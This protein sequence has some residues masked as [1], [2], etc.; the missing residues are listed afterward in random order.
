MPLKLLVDECMLDKRLVA[1]LRAAGH[2]LLTVT[3]AELIRKPDHVVFEAA[4]TADRMVFTCNCDD[5]VALAKEKQTHPGVLLVY[6]FNV[7]SKEMTYDDI[8]KSLDNLEGTSVTLTNSCHTLN[9][10]VY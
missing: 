7:P 3:D 1:R 4:I 9:S 2:D 6:K 5:F 10:Y 8:V